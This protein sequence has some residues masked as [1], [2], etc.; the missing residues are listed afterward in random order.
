MG[1]DLYGLKPTEHMKATPL[2]K[3]VKH[4]FNEFFKLEKGDQDKYLREYLEYEKANVGTYFRNN[5]WFWRP[6]WKYVCKVC[7]LST[8]AYQQGNRNEG[9]KVDEVTAKDIAVTL[10]LLLERG[11]VDR[12]AKEY[13]KSAVKCGGSPEYPFDVENVR[14]FAVFCDESGGFE[15]S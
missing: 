10:F 4:D 13:S 12:Y 7:N 6:L 5:V 9:Y 8:D 15:I 1:M 3:K 14:N 11:D 2:L